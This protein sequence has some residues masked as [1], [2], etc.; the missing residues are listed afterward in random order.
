MWILDGGACLRCR[1][2][3]AMVNGTSATREEIF[4][5]LRSALVRVDDRLSVEAVVDGASLVHD[6]G[7]DSLRLEELV[8]LIKREVT[9]ADLTPWY[10]RAA[11][12]GEDTVAGLLDF[13]VEGAL[14][15]A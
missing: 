5:W 7:L 3:H 14:P 10:V 11:R 8:A 13:L 4:T 12:D 15:R 6:L 9:G 2:G 1:R